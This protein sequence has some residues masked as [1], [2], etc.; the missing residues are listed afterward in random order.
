MKRAIQEQV[1]KDTGITVFIDAITR[2][3]SKNSSQF[4]EQVV[5]VQQQQM[6]QV[7]SSHSSS[8]VQFTQQVVLKNSDLL[9]EVLPEPSEGSQPSGRDNPVLITVREQ[10]GQTSGLLCDFIELTRVRF[11]QRGYGRTGQCS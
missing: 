2:P 7:K 10:K 4:T 11:K 6:E 9:E 1:Q 8:S 5:T 3:P